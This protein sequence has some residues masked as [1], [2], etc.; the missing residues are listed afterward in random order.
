MPPKRSSTSGVTPLRDFW[1]PRESDASVTAAAVIER[2]RASDESR[3]GTISKAAAAAKAKVFRSIFNPSD[4]V[5]VN[6]KELSLVCPISRTLMKIPARGAGCRHVEC[7]DLESFL[8]SINQVRSRRDPSGS[9]PECNS[10]LRAS[11]LQVDFWIKQLLEETVPGARKVVVNPDGSVIA[12]AQRDTRQDIAVDGFSQLGATQIGAP[13]AVRVKRERSEP[14]SNP[15]PSTPGE[16]ADLS[17]TAFEST[18]NGVPL[19]YTMNGVAVTWNSQA[20]VSTAETRYVATLG[21]PVCSCGETLAGAS[22]FL[23]C[24]CGRTGSE[25]DWNR[26]LQ[27]AAPNNSGASFD[28]HDFRDEQEIVITLNGPHGNRVWA[29]ASTSLCIGGVFATTSPR[30]L[31]ASGVELSNAE[32]AFVKAVLSDAFILDDPSKEPRDL[33]T[34]RTSSTPPRF[35]RNRS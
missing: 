30:C 13:I 15:S 35:T 18:Q 8:T 28:V 19:A 3:F 5:E 21:D 25:E 10:D 23:H 16:G 34:Y 2:C 14:P 9:C 12:S 27:I 32:V 33:P 22:G 20:T 29:Y 17:Q 24:C 31:V 4:D 26:R 7:F 11:T 1:A 6:C